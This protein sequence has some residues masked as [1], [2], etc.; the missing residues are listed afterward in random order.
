MAVRNKKV[1]LK[2]HVIGY[3]TVEDMEIVADT[4]ELRVPAGSR[5]VLIKNL[6]LSCDPWMRGRMSKHDDG[7]A[8][9]A[10][11]FVVGEVRR[12]FQ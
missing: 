8:V 10:P 7:A 2:R 9:P 12:P 11:D 4:I 6:Y 3:P 1:V 5:A